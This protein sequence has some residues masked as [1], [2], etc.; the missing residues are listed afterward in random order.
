[1]MNRIK[2]ICFFVLMVTLF[3]NAYGQKVVDKIVAKVGGEIVLLSEFEEQYNYALSAQPEIG[4]EE[5][6]KI[7]ESVIAQNLLVHQAKL[8]SIVVTSE[9]VE[10]QL[11]FKV[12]RI[13]Q[14]MNGD[15]KFFEDYYGENILQVKDRMRND[16][17][18]Q[19]M[20]QRMQMQ[21]LNEVRITPKEIKS[22]F[23]GIPTDSL[24]FLD[25]EVELAEI[26]I[27][28][29]VNEVEKTKA[30]LKLLEIRE[31]I[32]N[33][34]ETFET[35]AKRFSSDLGSGSKGGDLGF[36]KRGVFVPEFE[37]VA[38]GLK[39][40][41]LS[42]VVESEF[43]F[44]IIELIE[45]RGN[46]I[47]T[48]H[49]LIKPEL[50]ASDYELAQ[51]K[52]EE[53][54]NKVVN[55]SLEFKKAVR[56]YSDESSDSYADNGRIK[57]YQTGNNFFAM[58]AL[59]P[60]IYFAISDLNEGDISE[61]IEFTDVKGEKKF[62]F[63]KLLTKTKPHRASMKDDY[64]KIEQFAKESKK[65]TYFN[66]WIQEKL[67]ETFIDIDPAYMDCDNLKLWMNKN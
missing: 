26:V 8:D 27:K 47:H 20:A 12:E 61:I 17:T 18:N 1:M 51:A 15:E 55:D 65:N 4:E 32:V 25:A 58:G 23:D 40:G 53:I 29:T 2:S 52:L 62:R 44:H 14:Q 60:D 22:F 63:V 56:K 45:R 38:F 37:A 66:N 30:R 33:E 13:L 5:R 36:V 46:L 50:T 41:E 59:D 34:S 6:C 49:I 48:K 10:D 42:E 28:P 35:L 24:P 57:N 64:A 54:R 31:K 39:K 16:L 19:I 21:L 9:E 3:S 43:G 11:N 7:L 67:Q